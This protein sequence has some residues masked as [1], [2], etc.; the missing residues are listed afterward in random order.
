MT[1]T[2]A[3][4]IGVSI[5]A[6][7]IGLMIIGFTSH[8]ISSRLSATSVFNESASANAVIDSMDK[9]NSKLDW[10]VFATFIGLVLALVITSWYIGASPL[11][12]FIY[13]IVIVIGVVVGAVLSN[14]WES[15]SSSA[16]FSYMVGVLPLTNH[17]MS[18]LP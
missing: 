10:L 11:F 15:I 18:Y 6:V 16:A 14:T 17:L 12:F 13:F 9:V 1:A 2:D 4:F 3:V 8:T 5:F 7:A